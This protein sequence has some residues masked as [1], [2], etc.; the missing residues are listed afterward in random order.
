MLGGAAIFVV[1]VFGQLFAKIVDFDDVEDLHPNAEAI[2]YVFDEAI[3]EGYED[4]TYRPD[5]TINRAEFTK[6]L[7]GAVYEEG[8]ISGEDCFDDVADQWFAKY[9][10]KAKMEGVIEGYPDGDFKPAQ[11]ISFVEAAKIIVLAFGEP[12]ESNEVWYVPFVQRLS[13]DTVIPWTVDRLDKKITRGEMAEMIFR[14]RAEIVGRDYM[15]FDRELGELKR[16]GDYFPNEK[17]DV[18]EEAD[19]EDLVEEEVV[20]EEEGRSISVF[21]TYRNDGGKTISVLGCDEEVFVPTYGFV[22]GCEF[23]CNEGYKK[24]EDACVKIEVPEN[25]FLNGYEFICDLGYKR[26][27]DKCVELE[28][29]ENSFVEGWHYKCE[30]GFIPVDGECVPGMC[31]RNEVYVPEGGRIFE[32]DFECQPGYCRQGNE[33]VEMDV[34]YGGQAVQCDFTCGRGYCKDE[35]TCKEVYVPDN[36]KAAG[37]DFECNVGYCRKDNQCVRVRVPEFGF[38]DGCDFRCGLGY[39]RVGDSC[40]KDEE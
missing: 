22:D 20:E 29:V 24:T 39:S 33:C 17:P 11:E 19:S 40:V 13:E 26:E 27:G 3:V 4:G 23:R 7:V 16:G 38:Q 32:C 15:E 34:P 37:C 25:G 35:G 8:D 18:E 5:A 9:V 36:A 30:A 14:I 2:R 21:D 10:C 6:I 31:S 12:T 28:A 1:G